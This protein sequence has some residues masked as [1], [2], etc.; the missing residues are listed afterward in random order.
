LRSK[1]RLFS[2]DQRRP[3]WLEWLVVTLGTAQQIEAA[4]RERRAWK[5]TRLVLDVGDSGAL[6]LDAA[7]TVASAAQH[8]LP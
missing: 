8:P 7:R 6:L 1:W 3:F 4:L 2:T 5:K